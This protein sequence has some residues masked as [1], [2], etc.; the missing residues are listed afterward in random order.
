MARGYQVFEKAE[1]LEMACAELYRA[2]AEQFRA[3]ADAHGL[4]RLLEQEEIQ[5]AR[6]VRLLAARYS[7]DSKLFENVEVAVHELEALLVE[8]RQALRDVKGG[9]W[10][11]DLDVVKGELADLEFRF[12]AA[13]A[14]V[15]A[16]SA[17]PGVKSFFEQLAAQDAGHAELLRG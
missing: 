12:A 11:D 17:D 1:Q 15:I 2:L 9:A 6:R 16:K 3:D 8:A 13:H 4:F 14:H 10:G 7:H 5:H